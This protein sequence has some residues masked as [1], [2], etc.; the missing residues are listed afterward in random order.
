MAQ[1]RAYLRSLTVFDGEL[2]ELDADAAPE[3]PEEFFVEWLRDAVEAGVR[4]P[5]AMTLST[6]GVD[7][8]PSGRVLILK[9]VDADGWQFAV[10]GSSPK[11]Q[12]LIG[13][14]SAALTF[15]WSQQAR[16]IRVRGPVVAESAERSAADFLDRPIGSRAEALSGMQSRPLVDRQD[17]EVAGK[18]NRERIAQEPQLV[19]P[20]WT[21][22]TL[23]ADQVEFWQGDKER[24]HTRLLYVRTDG[25]WRRHLLWP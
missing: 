14:P 25:G 16:Q 8:V 19:S 1:I 20:A 15:Y 13:H 4:E 17:L 23:R 18:E 6:L 3:R 9:N 5:H 2:P 11:G 12:E 21:L 10:Q 24:K 22:Y 7:G